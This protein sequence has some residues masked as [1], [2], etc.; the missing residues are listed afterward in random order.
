[1][2]LSS[3]LGGAVLEGIRG[4]KWTHHEGCV[5]GKQLYKGSMAVTLSG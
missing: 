3:K 1:M 5:N 4:D 2:G